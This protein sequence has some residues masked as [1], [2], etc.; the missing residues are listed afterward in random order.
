MRLNLGCGADKRAG[1]HNV[2]KSGTF[3]PDEI[4]D[5][6]RLPWPWK[7]G[8]VDEIL[9][10]HVLEH[11]GATP[12]AYIG[13]MKELW[14]V[15]R[16]G[17]TITIVV[18]HPRHD[19]FLDDPTH[20]RAVTGTG[21]ALFSRKANEYWVQNG[22][23]NTPLAL[24][25]GIDLEPLSADMTLA[26]PWASEMKAGRIDQSALEQAAQRY[27]NVIRQQTF[28]LRVNKP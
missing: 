3:S 4:V 18:P 10:S 7:D 26:E 23:A 25:L 8:S 24:H 19:D 12:E 2:D 15:C 27:N 17:A 11:L 13:I 16:G 22:F 21:L 14:R 20:V 6:E 1:W 5:L 9:L 28:V